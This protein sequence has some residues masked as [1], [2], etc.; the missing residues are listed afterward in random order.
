MSRARTTL[1]A[2][3]LALAIEAPSMAQERPAIP[4]VRCTP[5]TLT[6]EV[7]VA[8]GARS[9]ALR[10][11]NDDRGDFPAR[12][13]AEVV[14]ERE[15]NGAWVRAGVAGMR[16]RSNCR[17]AATECVTLAPHESIE[18]VPWQAMLGDGQ[19]ECTRCANAPAGRYR[20]VVTTCQS[21]FQPR[22]S[23]S[24]PFTLPAAR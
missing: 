17:D 24:A 12:I 13:N 3:T 19:C 11:T 23:V 7:R 16:V 14:V 20:F 10:V 18:V 2:L 4:E 6:A 21:C 1:F 9:V 8:R 22:E 15:V 5:V